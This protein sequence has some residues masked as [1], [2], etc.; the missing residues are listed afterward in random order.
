[1]GQ[2]NVIPEGFKM[3]KTRSKLFALVMRNALPITEF[4]KIPCSR[5]IELAVLVE[6]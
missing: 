4:I 6:L 3:S 1:M 2:A 5:V